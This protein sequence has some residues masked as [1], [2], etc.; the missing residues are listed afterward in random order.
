MTGVFVVSLDFE[1]H[2]GVHDHVPL[3]AYRENLLGVRRAV[4]AMLEMFA[5]FGVHATWATVG[6]LLCESRRQLLAALPER[7]P[8]YTEPLRSAY[9]LLDTLGE[10]ER[11]DP[12]HFA[13]SLIR[14]IA[15]VPG[16]EIATH[17]LTHYYCLEPGQSLAEF[18]DDLQAA[19]RLMH[20]A[21]GTSPR[22]IVFPRNEFA[23][24]HLPI[25]RELGLL[26][27][28]GQADAW[29]F[30]PRARAEESLARRAVRL[31]DAYVPITGRHTVPLV[32]Q[33][34]PVNVPASRY[35][36]PYSV[37]RRRL[38]A[39]RIHRITAEL[40]EAARNGRVFHL[41]W[42]PHDFGVYLSENLRVLRRVLACFARLRDRYGME[43][44]TMAG[45]AE[46]VLS[47]R[48]RAERSTREA[49][50]MTELRTASRATSMTS[51]ART[52]PSVVI[53]LVSAVALVATR[54]IATTIAPGASSAGVVRFAK[55]GTSHFDR[56]TGSP[57]R[58][59]QRWMRAH[60]WRMRV[61]T[62]YFDSRLSWFPQA[63]VYKDLYAIYTGSALAEAHP[64]WILRDASGNP[65]YI[66]WGC[67]DGRCPQYAGDIGNPAFRAHWIETATAILRPGYVG[68]FVDDVNMDLSRVSDV[69]TAP[70]VPIDSR[71]GA[72]T[73]NADWRRYM[74]EF[75][76]EIRRAFPD[77][78]I[79]HNALWFFG[80][81]DPFIQ[82]QLRSADYV[83][84]ERGVNDAGVVGGMRVFGFDRLLRHIDW[85]HDQGKGVVFDAGA[86]TKKEREY[87][88]AAY[89]LVSSGRDA[90]GN[91]PGGT[92]DD[93]WHGY[94]VA[95]GAPL[96]DRY[97]WHGVLRR[98]F[99]HGIVL[100]NPPGPDKRRVDLDRAAVTLGCRRAATLHLRPAEGA[101]LRTA[102][103]PARCDAAPGAH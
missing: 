48:D 56:Y 29:A 72:P 9:R 78:E 4:P 73:T 61:Y 28:R 37:A 6:L 82:R 60:Y 7:R 88:L 76:E 83:E 16:Q 58:A 71:T 67:G 15:A 52:L 93:W 103:T 99:E 47:Q 102:V 21:L 101:V 32:A 95:L 3:S 84:V 85:L 44:L 97:A 68:L 30:R 81:D 92:P 89:F 59:L 34:A 98:D 20:D 19:M 10:N 91:D 13:P 5:A 14:A 25:C 94:D 43:S 55:S 64:E 77:R 39:L 66:P 38:E 63:W 36:R 87:G 11:D 74:A 100:L 8:S 18:R 90:L 24:A 62:P 1:L 86:R 31:I 53:L 46:R 35:L 49:G 75:T 70:M 17:T 22:S 96:A 54:A 51:A 2:W 42:H 79:V 65:L 26:A 50:R 80:H 57:T 23:D 40:R 41:W 45:V 12:L 69:T 33:D 27:Y